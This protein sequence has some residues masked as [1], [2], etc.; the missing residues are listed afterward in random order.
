MSEDV[1]T[2]RQ[3]VKDLR[4]ERDELDGQLTRMRD[5]LRRVASALKGDPGPLRLWSWHD[6]PEI[7]ALAMEWGRASWAHFD[8][9]LTSQRM[10]VSRE[11]Y[12]QGL[13]DGERMAQSDW[14]I[15]GDLDDTVQT[16]ISSK[17]IG[18]YDAF[19]KT[20]ADPEVD[21]QICA[22]TDGGS[23]F[24]FSNADV[25]RSVATAPEPPAAPDIAADVHDAFYRL[26]IAQRDG[27]WREIE[28]LKTVMHSLRSE[29]ETL[30]ERE[31]ARPKS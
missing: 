17:S 19:L 24:H 6:L 10:D 26:A 20:C 29:L 27:A 31:R 1:E 22:I 30:R 4:E 16:A 13:R 2:L 28:N 3:R 14:K 11:S 15:G 12:Q 21:V 7:A 25:R 23:V 9:K 5:L 18:N 8:A